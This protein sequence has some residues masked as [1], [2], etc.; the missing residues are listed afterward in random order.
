MPRPSKGARLYWR[1]D[2]EQWVILDGKKQ[3]GTGTA[4]RREAESRLAEYTIQRDRPGVANEPEKLTLAAALET[5]V[6]EHARTVK[7]PER[8][9][10]AMTPLLDFWGELPVSAV[11]KA[12]S[13]R[14]AS[15]RVNKNGKPTAPATVRREL[16]VLQA[17][18]NYSA[19]EGLLT[20]TVNVTLPDAPAPK[21]RWLTRDEAARLI[22]AA[23][24]NAPHIAWFILIALYTGTRKRAVL[25]LRFEPHT[26]GGWIDCD[27]GVIYRAAKDMRKTKKKKPPVRMPRKLLAHMKRRK[28]NGATWA[29]EWK[30]QR[31]GDIKTAWNEARIAA[32]LP[33]VTPHTLKH[34]AVT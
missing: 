3:R 6:E 11:T 8:I 7:D 20:R 24:K 12:T 33:D 21:E 16:G 27:R 26:A 25:D 9:I 18:I 28:A 30:G 32:D 13:R 15:V 22:R 19:E 1:K 2:T 17:A 5:Y 14:Y 10:Y 29:V 23:R 34:T 4:S 31:I